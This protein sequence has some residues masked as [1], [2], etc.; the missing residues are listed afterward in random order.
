M[1]INDDDVTLQG[2]CLG[3]TSC[4]FNEF[5]ELAKEVSFYGNSTGYNQLCGRNSSVFDPP[6]PKEV[7][8]NKFVS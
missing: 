6:K 4:N 7:K 5:R 2:A 3:N 8:P 1:R